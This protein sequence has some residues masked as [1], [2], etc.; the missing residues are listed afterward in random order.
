MIPVECGVK[1]KISSDSS[2]ESSW[3]Q[4]YPLRV[5]CFCPRQLLQKEEHMTAEKKIAQRKMT[6]LQFAKQL[7]NVSET[8]RR[9]GE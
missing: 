6:L 7:R 4:Q 2:G 8:C 3:Q 9:R 5:G 1:V